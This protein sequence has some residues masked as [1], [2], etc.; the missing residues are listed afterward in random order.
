MPDLF[1]RHTQAFRSK[2]GRNKSNRKYMVL[3]ASHF[4][5]L[6]EISVVPEAGN[7][8]NGFST[9]SKPLT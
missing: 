3:Q 1:G 4:K 2:S 7:E 9:S 5:P 8:R 6:Y